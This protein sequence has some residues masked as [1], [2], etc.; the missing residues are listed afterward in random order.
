M[1]D[2]DRYR[3][4]QPRRYRSGSKRDQFGNII[5]GTG[6]PQ[7]Q[8]ANG[9][10]TGGL[11]TGAPHNWSAFDAA[12]A[13]PSAG[14]TRPAPNWTDTAGANID[15]GVAAASGQPAPMPEQA[16]TGGDG[17]FVLSQAGQQQAV[18]NSMARGNRNSMHGQ[19]AIAASAPPPAAPA[20][21]V[22]NIQRADPASQRN[23]DGTAAADPAA[24]L[25][26][27]QQLVANP[28]AFARTAPPAAM[29]TPGQAVIEAT[30]GAT[31]NAPFRGSTPAEVSDFYATDPNRAGNNAELQQGAFTRQAVPTPY[32][33]V[34]SGDATSAPAPIAGRSAPAGPATMALAGN[35]MARTPAPIMQPAPV[36]AAPK[37]VAPAPVAAAPSAPTPK[38]VGAG[39]AFEGW[40]GMVGAMRRT[41]SGSAFQG[42]RDLGNVLPMAG[43]K[44]PSAPVAAPITKAA[45]PAPPVPMPAVQSNPVPQTVKPAALP[46]PAA[47]VAPGGGLMNGL[48]A[49]ARSVTGIQPNANAARVRKMGGLD[50]EE[51]RRKR[52]GAM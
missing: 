18:A 23:P 42:L 33:V 14:M 22:A 12:F 50:D 48:G 3:Y 5:P 25:R 9:L 7:A 16:A 41:G 6:A 19:A 38:L 24:M 20:A 37:P 17:P 35:P 26:F 13:R 44:R 8:V 29:T 47:P 1:S 27:N 28:G 11:S 21:T 36:A 49:M 34:S 40:N 2:R 10:Q 31:D 45:P 46:A 15:A 4:Q 32:G 43:E 51:T 39:T 52:V 30:G